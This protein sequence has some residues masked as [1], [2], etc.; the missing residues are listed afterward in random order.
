MSR[1]PPTPGRDPARDKN[2]LPARWMPGRIVLVAMVLLALAAT[3][4]HLVAINR[5]DPWYRNVDMNI[6]SMADA[7][8]F[9]S[10]VPP[11][12]LDQPG[13]P[14]K[15][16]LALH[17]RVL[18][19]AGALP[20]WNLKKLD[21]S[22]DPVREIPGLI[23]ALRLQ[24][25][26]FLMVLLLA[27]GALA[28][29]V[30][31]K[32][33]PACLAVLLLAGSPAIVFHGLLS[34]T[35]QL[36][37]L[38]GGVLALFCTLQATASRRLDCRYLWLL[39][40]GSLVGFAFLEKLLVVA[41]AAMCVGWCW[42]AALDAAPAAESD[43]AAGESL[44][45]WWELLPA[46]AGLATLW[47]LFRL[48]PHHE[49]LG[50]VAL[51]RMRLAAVGVAVL[52]LLALWPGRGRLRGFC[53]A[54]G[55]ELALLGA[56]G[57]AIFPLTYLVLQTVLSESDAGN[58]LARVLSFALNPG[59]QM[60][61]LADSPHVGEVF[62]RHLRENAVMF[63]GATALSLALLPVQAIPRRLKLLVALL[64]A[65]AF[66]LV[67]LL[68]KRHFMIHYEIYY[69]MPLFLA[70]ALALGAGFEQLAARRP[71]ASGLV[72]ATA[73]VAT[74]VILFGQPRAQHFYANYQDDAKFPLNDL[75]VTFLFDHEAKTRAYLDLMARHYGDREGFRRAVDRF[76][77]DPANHF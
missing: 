42:L 49:E 36:C 65:T 27:A 61:L 8:S 17:Y 51:A 50:A 37:V 14:T 62:V 4:L 21:A 13:V 76:L 44:G 38:C 41:Y 12:Q 9:N 73:L 20:V 68:S 33:A 16:L 35:E 54:R 7:L 63:T 71:W 40:A 6:H 34:R 26:A 72:P 66:G 57:L 56:G 75:T 2:E 45:Y 74:G 55:R 29:S 3:W 32:L 5:T 39:L 48:S 67:A 23:H 58:Y 77:A 19:F 22:P 1:P 64:C 15:F 60:A 10:G 69:L 11:N 28:W 31:R 46:A 18:H 70:S 30:S 52:P 25:R 24:S 47:L 53:V 43:S 59:L